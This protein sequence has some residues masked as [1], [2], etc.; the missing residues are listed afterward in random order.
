MPR[1]RGE[2]DHEDDEPHALSPPYGAEE[3]EEEATEDHEED[4][5]LPHRT[6]PWPWDIPSGDEAPLREVDFDNWYNGNSNH[7]GIRFESTRSTF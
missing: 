1:A 5:E 2:E 6:V 7:N 3:E 4:T